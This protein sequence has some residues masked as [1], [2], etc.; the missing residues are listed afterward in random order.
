MISKLQFILISVNF[1]SFRY[2]YLISFLL[3][4]LILFRFIL[5]GFRFR[6]LVFLVYYFCIHFIIFIV[7]IIIFILSFNL[8]KII[9]FDLNLQSCNSWSNECWNVLLY[10]IRFH[11]LILSFRYLFYVISI[12][13]LL[14][15]LTIFKSF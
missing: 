13:F 6:R 9:I 11:I 10:L 12:N 7:I 2:I 3:N 14:L 5:F 15:L 8:S 1:S 4:L